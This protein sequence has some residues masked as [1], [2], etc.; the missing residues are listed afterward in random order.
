M[1]VPG[2]PCCSGVYGIRNTTTGKWYVGSS[3]GS[4][5]TRLIQHRKTLRSRSHYNRHLQSSYNKYGEA[6]FV[7]VVLDTCEPA[8]CVEIEQVWIDFFKSADSRHGYN[9]CTRAGSCL[10]VRCSDKCREI[11]GARYRGKKR[12]PEDRARISAT[13]TGG[14]RSPES[15]CRMTEA[16]NRPEVKA[17]IAASFARP[18]VREKMQKAWKAQVGKKASDAARAKMSAKRKGKKLSPQV[19]AKMSAAA[20]LR[21]AHNPLSI[22]ARKKISDTLRR[23]A[24]K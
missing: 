6:A 14:K 5:R 13:L 1:L 17:K 4:L 8:R 15:V 7:V 18:E 20:K 24:W 16:Q 23:R 12:T 11:T 9:I 10:G 3:A 21:W 19:R 2:V 22:E